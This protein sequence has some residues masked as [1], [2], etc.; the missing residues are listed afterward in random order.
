M[1]L[2][3]LEFLAESLQY[4]E[5]VRGDDGVYLAAIYLQRGAAI[6][7]VISAIDCGVAIENLL[8]SAR[9]QA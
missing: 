8:P 5:A 3:H 9:R 4:H 2:A 1:I 7:D 6:A